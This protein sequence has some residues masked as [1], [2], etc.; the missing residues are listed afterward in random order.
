MAEIERKLTGITRSTIALGLVELRA[1]RCNLPAAPTAGAADA[2]RFVSLSPSLHL[3]RPSPFADTSGRQ[4]SD[5][6]CLPCLPLSARRGRGGQCTN[7]RPN[8]GC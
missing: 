5:A 4:G 3:F 6:W 8:G 7:T 1:A 2:D